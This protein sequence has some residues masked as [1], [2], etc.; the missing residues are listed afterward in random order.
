M[1]QIAFLLVLTLL[2]ACTATQVKQT[3]VYNDNLPK[4]KLIL[5][6]TLSNQ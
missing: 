4:P 6:K 1:N 3:P 5:T 2:S